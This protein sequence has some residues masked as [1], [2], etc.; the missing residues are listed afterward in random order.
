MGAGGGGGGV[1]F[2][3]IKAKIQATSSEVHTAITVDQ[4]EP[5]QTKGPFEC[6][7]MQYQGWEGVRFA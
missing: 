6:Y 4:T 7:V 1:A 2:E 3:T 5:F